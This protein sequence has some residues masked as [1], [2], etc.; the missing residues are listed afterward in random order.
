MIKEFIDYVKDNPKGYW[1]KAKWYGWGW[2]PVTWQGLAVIVIYLVIITAP[3][4]IFAKEIESSRGYS[5]AFFFFAAVS[6]VILLWICLAKGERPQW[7][8]GNPR[9]RK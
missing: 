8:W 4:I 9:R 1:F 7:N 6:T 2:V 3:G 5:I